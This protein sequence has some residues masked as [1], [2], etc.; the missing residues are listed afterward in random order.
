MPIFEYCCPACNKIFEELVQGREERI[1]CPI[2]E[3]D[4]SGHRR[5]SVCSVNIK[6]QTLKKTASSGVSNCGP[7]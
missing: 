3:C 5:L 6:N 1:L 7:A 4:A 2:C